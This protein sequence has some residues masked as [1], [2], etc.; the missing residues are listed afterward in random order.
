M[1]AFRECRSLRSGVR[2][3]DGGKAG[4]EGLQRECLYSRHFVIRDPLT[5]DNPAGQYVMLAF[6][7]CRSPRLPLFPVERRRQMI[8]VG[9]EAVAIAIEVARSRAGRVDKNIEHAALKK[10]WCPKNSITGEQ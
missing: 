5:A 6:R 1:L 2:L 4:K 3:S 8:D 10:K 7:E 9:L